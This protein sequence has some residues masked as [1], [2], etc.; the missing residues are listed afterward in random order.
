MKREKTMQELIDLYGIELYGDYN[1]G[2]EFIRAT[3][4][5][6]S[7]FYHDDWTYVN[8]HKAKVFKILKVKRKIWF[9]GMNEK[10]EFGKKSKQLG[11]TLRNFS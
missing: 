1:T 8:E 7:L 6:H 4:N 2:A 10:K 9:A 3:K 11:Y 5:T